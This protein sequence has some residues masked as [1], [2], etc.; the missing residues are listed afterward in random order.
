MT[1]KT[2]TLTWAAVLGGAALVSA[3]QISDSSSPERRP[4]SGVVRG[5][6]R[7]D[8][9]MARRWQKSDDLIGKKVVNQSN[10]D[11]G[12]IEDIVVD[13]GT[14]R[15]LYGVLSFGGFLGL[16]DK[17]FAVPMDSLQLSGDEK[18]F[19]LNV[20]K[21]R[22]KNAEGFDKHHWPNFTDEQWATK[23]YK[24]YDRQPYW[25]ANQ[26]GVSHVNSPSSP[27]PGGTVSGG[28]I[29]NASPSNNTVSGGTI[30]NSAYRE[31]WN[32]R[33]SVWAKASDLSGKDVRNSSNEDLGHISDLVI[34]A[35]GSR[36]LY[37]I[38]SFRGKMFAVPW[39]A[40]TLSS[41]GKYLL[42]NVSKDQLKDSM[43]FTKDNWPNFTDSQWNANTY[44]YYRQPRYW[45]GA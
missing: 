42:L 12:K 6:P 30:S 9:A 21:D 29:T 13:A 45:E 18:T 33:V 36:I 35:D 38:L 1:R 15:V 17:W 31:R 39:T 11:L 5:T 20:D 14:G 8:F 2:I 34:D 19:I 27:T 28:T 23:T 37:G 26:P 44:D 16:G 22:L 43:G 25:A 4:Q 24:Y 10:E 3:Q 32:Q 40:L 7:N 41:D